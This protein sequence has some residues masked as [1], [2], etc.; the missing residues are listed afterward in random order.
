MDIKLNY[1]ES[2]DGFNLVLLHGNGESC[3]YFNN[4]IPF[5]SKYFHVIAPDTRGHG[6]SERGNSL[7]TLEQFAL[8]LKDFLD[9]RELK[10]IHLLGF[11]DG[12]NIALLFSLKF[13]QYVKKLIINGANLY[14]KGMKKT[15]LLAVYFDFALASFI[16]LFDKRAVRKKEML[17]L[18]T[19]QPNISTVELKKINIP[20]L[21]IAGTND[22]IKDSHTELIAS[23]IPLARKI[24]IQGNHFIAKQ[25]SETF[26]A[27]V[28]AFLMEN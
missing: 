28:Y 21:V 10:E 26:N 20:T 9:E 6:K 12:A 24:I 17:D 3:E 19:G 13:P 25:N 16:A 5:F 1:I 2:G 4:Q 23:S 11:S 22:M 27:A 8:D 7:F 18:M 15:T 14:P